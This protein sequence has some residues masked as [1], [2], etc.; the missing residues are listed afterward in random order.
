MFC[1]F[2]RRLNCDVAV[3]VTGIAAAHTLDALAAQ[4]E[5]FGCLRAFRNVNR[6]L[7]CQRGHFNFAAQC[8]GGKADGHGAVQVVTVALKNLVLFDTNLD[9]QIT[10][11]A[12][13]GA[14]LA[15]AG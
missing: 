8:C 2:H 7:A 13:V 10:G 11:W 1:Q 3:Q 15:V 14:G 12:T 4:T 6:G 5:L 9:V